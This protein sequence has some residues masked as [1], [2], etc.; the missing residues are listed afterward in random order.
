[1]PGYALFPDGRPCDATFFYKT[2][3]GDGRS[4]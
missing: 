4:A 1:V 3:T 2:L